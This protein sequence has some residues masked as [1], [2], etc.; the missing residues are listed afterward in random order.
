MSNSKQ[1][2]QAAAALLVVAFTDETAADQALEAMKAARK[3]HQ[4]SFDDAAVIRHDAKGE[5]HFHET[6]DMGSGKA[7]GIGAVV[8]GVLGILGGPAGIVVGA[9][10]GAAAGSFLGLADGG[11]RDD[12]LDAVGGALKPGTSA[13]VA[14][15]SHGLLKALQDLLTEEEIGAAVNQLAAELS[16]RLAENKCVAIGVLRTAKGLGLKE[17]AAAKD[18]AELV[19]AVIGSAAAFFGSIAVAPN[20]VAWEVVGASGEG[21]TAEAGAIA[22]AGVVQLDLAAPAEAPAED[23]TPS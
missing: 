7:A 4:F 22:A 17:I 11:F 10:L 5:V 21:L 23:A 20:A 8:G 14:I 12:R 6:G 15:T 1:Q 13:V 16:A 9:G 18:P 19:N 3:Q 2:G